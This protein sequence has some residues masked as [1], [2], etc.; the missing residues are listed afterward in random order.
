MKFSIIIENFDSKIHKILPIS[1]KVLSLKLNTVIKYAFLASILNF[2]AKLFNFFFKLC[3]HG[4]KIFD[5]IENC[6]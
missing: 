3:F 2:A 1:D 5:G 6:G 4:S